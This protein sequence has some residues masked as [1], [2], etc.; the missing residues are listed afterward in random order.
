MSLNTC[1]VFYRILHNT[2]SVL[3]L[4]VE[5]TDGDNVRC[6]NQ[7]LSDNPPGVSVYEVSFATLFMHGIVLV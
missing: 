7:T 1:V 5:D 4:Q 6:Y 3:Q 2:T